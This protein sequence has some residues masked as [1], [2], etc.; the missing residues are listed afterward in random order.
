MIFHFF[1]FGGD[2]QILIVGLI[3]FLPESL[4]LMLV[5]LM[6]LLES[7]VVICKFQENKRVIQ[8]NK[9]LIVLSSTCLVDAKAFLRLA[10]SSRRDSY[11]YSSI[12]TL[13][14]EIYEKIIVK[15]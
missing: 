8:P 11:R 6:D 4:I 15:L 14:Q 3:V 9:L 2:L 13:I 10:F 5:V 1:L 12:L 7:F